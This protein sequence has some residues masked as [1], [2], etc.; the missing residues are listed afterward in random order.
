MSGGCEL[1][2]EL[3]QRV[4]TGRDEHAGPVTASR[5]RVLGQRGKETRPGKRRL[6]TPRAADDAGTSR[7]G[8]GRDELRDEALSA[9]VPAGIFALETQ[10]A[11]VR[12]G[13]DEGATLERVVRTSIQHAVGDPPPRAHE[14]DLRRLRDV[15]RRQQLCRLFM[16]ERFAERRVR[17]TRAV[18][19][20]FDDRGDDGVV[21]RR[22]PD[23]DEHAHDVLRRDRRELARSERRLVHEDRRF[24]LA[25]LTA[26]LETQLFDEYLP[27]VL[28]CSKC[29]GLSTGAVQ[30]EHELTPEALAVRI[31]CDE[32]F[33]LRQQLDV[34]TQRELRLDA[35]FGGSEARLLETGD[36][37]AR[38]R[39]VRQVGDRRLAPER[40]RN[41]EQHRG[42]GHTALGPE[43]AR[44]RNE[45]LEPEEVD[46]LGIDGE[47]VARWLRQQHRRL[48]A[49]AAFRLEDLAQVRDVDL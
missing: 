34:P 38:P 18:T 43:R 44:R 39:L 28:I 14:R 3:E 20:L 8:D 37:E 6:A 11:L 2:R 17:T 48:R 5:Q 33:E 15:D 25:Q 31:A 19:A 7:A 45:A 4:E 9:E 27:R 29:V 24:H 47:D 12:T 35:V 32:C 42:A 46:V 22:T 41:S 1:A 40:E 10:Q 30:R 16:V 49:R 23:R 13:A 26:G 36:L 21:R